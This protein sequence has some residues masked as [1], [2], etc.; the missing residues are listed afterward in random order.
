MD[1]RAAPLANAG[2]RELLQRIENALI[3]DGY[4]EK[5]WTTAR[6]SF[7]WRTH[8]A[9]TAERQDGTEKSMILPLVS[10]GLCAV[11]GTAIGTALFGST[12]GVFGTAIGAGVGA[13]IVAATSKLPLATASR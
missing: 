10:T 13:M 7:S 6:G 4:D 12:V 5:L 3:D 9:G 1:D 2:Q 8:R 11:V